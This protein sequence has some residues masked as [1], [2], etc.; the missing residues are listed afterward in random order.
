VPPAWNAG[1]IVSTTR[2]VL[3]AETSPN[4]AIALLLTGAV[5]ALSRGLDVNRYRG[6]VQAAL[7]ERLDR[8]VSLGRMHLGLVPLGL[9][10]EDAAIADDPGFQ[11]GSPFLRAEELY[12]TPRLLPLLRGRFELR[13]LELRRPVIELLRNAAGIWNFTTLGR[14]E[15]PEP[16]L[17]LHR[18]V[19]T[20]GQVA[21]TDPE[22]CGCRV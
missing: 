16:T 11:T 6:R 7:A 14:D 13:S 9:R 12:V 17:V 3:S 21:V 4:A 20:N 2:K 10:V 15:K 22:G 8:E 18:L 5:L 19:I 1:L